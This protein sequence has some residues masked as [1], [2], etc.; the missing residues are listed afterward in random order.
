MSSMG[1]DKSGDQA[2]ADSVWVKVVS[3]TVRSGFPSTSIVDD[4]LVMDVNGVGDIEYRGEFSSSIGNQ[5]FRVVQNGT[6]VLDT[7]AAETIGTVTSVSVATGDT[8]ELQAFRDGFGDTII[9]G[10]SFTYLGYSQTAQ[11]KFIASD[12][13]IDWS[14]IP[15][16]SVARP[17]AVDPI[18]IN[19]D[20]ETD[21]H[22]AVEYTVAS[23]VEINW[24]IETDLLLIPQVVTPPQV[25][26]F[27]D[28]AVS[29]HTADGK[30]V[31][32]FPCT[33]LAAYNWSREDTEVSIC[34]LTVLTQGAP[35]LVEELRQ[36][37]HWVTVWFDDTPVWTGAIQGIR[38]TRERT[39][40]SARDVATFMWRTRTPITKTWLDTAPQ[41]IAEGVWTSM[42]ELHGVRASPI[43]LPGVAYNTFTVSAKADQR[44]LHQFMDELV[45]VGLHWTVIAGRPV[46]GQF[47]RD[48][49][50]E[51]HEC[52]FM[53]ELERRRDGIDT[54]N[55]VRVQGQNWAQ[56]AY[57]PLAGL[58]LQTIVSLDDMFGA[59]NIQRAAQRYAMNNV[60]LR[61][62]LIVPPNASLHPQAPVTLD[63]LVPGKVFIVHSETVSQLMRLDQVIVA[64]SPGVFDVQVNLVVLEQNN[65]DVSL[66]GG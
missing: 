52:D 45:K 61:D 63:D 53:V 14:V 27:A 30:P 6:T 13:V 62:E 65:N 18:V 9:P 28:V 55:D 20:I 34:N 2:I 1:M 41:R 22:V 46:L 37:V 25:F 31:G 44:M 47:P 8:L 19:W 3:F 35:D 43:V 58:R 56:T 5:N 7:V 23:N 15:D 54:Y 42:L 59:S 38:I 40:I 26:T 33:V 51:L 48:P 16:L 17:F 21:M 49:V 39:T 66:V 12:V 64:G 24:N 32:D 11:E 50:A 4:A 60:R 10:G 57:V 29:V 36:W